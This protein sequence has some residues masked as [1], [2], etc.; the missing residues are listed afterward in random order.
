MK[1][2]PSSGPIYLQLARE[3]TR[4]I[5]RGDLNPGD[6]LPPVRELARRFRVNP[7]TVVQVYRELERRE[8]ACTQ[9]GRGTFV[10]E[11]V[12]VDA[13][14]RALLKNAASSFW[15]EIRALGLSLEDAVAALEEVSCDRQLDRGG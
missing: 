1:L 7:N 12:D 10:R 5:A 4:W 3:I 11:D 15:E 9:R 13:L 2:D 6:R 8:V 14:R